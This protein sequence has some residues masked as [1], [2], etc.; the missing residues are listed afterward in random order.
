MGG[1]AIWTLAGGKGGAGRTLLAANLGIQLA[2]AGRRVVLVDLDLQVGMLH[3]ALGFARVKRGLAALAAGPGTALAGAAVETSIP[4]LR[5]VG[6]LLGARPPHDPQALIARVREGLPAIDADVVIIDCGSGRSA[7]VLEAF[8]LGSLGIVVAAAEPPALEAA[9]LFAEAH[10]RRCL[11]RAL[12]D[13]TRGAIDELL[14]AEGLHAARLPF[15]DLM[16][17]I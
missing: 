8:A 12:P 7:E 6:G 3:A 4:H 15:R 10:L 13:D 17:R 2:R 9:V 16:I 1:P 5:L 14:A 11:D